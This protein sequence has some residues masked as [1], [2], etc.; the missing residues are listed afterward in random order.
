MIVTI[1]KVEEAKTRNGDDYL[2]V[3]GIDVKSQKESFKNI[4]SNLKEKWGLIKEGRTLEFKMVQTYKDGKSNWNVDNILE[5]GSEQLPPPQTPPLPEQGNPPPEE[6][7]TSRAK[8]DPS[9]QERGMW[10]KQLGDDLRSGH[11]DRSKP[12]GKALRAQYFTEMFRV[13]D[14]HIEHK[15]D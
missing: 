1:T 15:E 7:Q 11:I 9:G 2:K 14:I 12:F 10:W 4:F 3:T 8:Y 5:I 13:L 6:I